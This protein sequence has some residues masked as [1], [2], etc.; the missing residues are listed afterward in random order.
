[1]TPPNAVAAPAAEKA[2]KPAKK[3]KTAVEKLNAKALAIAAWALETAPLFQDGMIPEVEGKPAPFLV[4][5]A[6]ANDAVG[7]LQDAAKKLSAALLPLHKAKWQ[8]RHR[9]RGEHRPGDLLALKAKRVGRFE[10]AYSKEDLG[11]L[12]AVS[13]HGK[14]VKVEVFKDGLKGECLGLVHAHWLETRK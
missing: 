12:R 7:L 10:G 9:A 2:A 4:L 1:M 13:V 5:L 14:L 8:P 6:N 3:P 11:S